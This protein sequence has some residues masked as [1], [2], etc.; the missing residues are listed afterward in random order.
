MKPPP[1]IV[2]FRNDLRLSDNPTLTEALKEGC[3]VVPV[4]VWDPER[5]APW[6]PGAAS[7]S[8]LHH[9]L[10]ALDRSIHQLGSRLIVR[11]GESLRELLK[12][13][14]ETGARRIYRNTRYEPMVVASDLFIRK[15][16]EYGG[17]ETVELPGNLLFEP[18]EVEKKSGGPYQVFTP[19]WRHCWPIIQ[20]SPPA[21]LPA[22]ES[23][24]PVSPKLKSLNIDELDLAPPLQWDRGFYEVFTPGEAGAHEALQSFLKSY[25]SDYQIR[26][27]FPAQ[28]A[29]SSLS[30]HLHFGEI[31][32]RQIYDGLRYEG[33]EHTKGAER[34]MAE[35]IWR[36]FAH[37]LLYH[38]PH[39]TDNPLKTN[40]ER[41]PWRTSPENLERWQ[42][43][44]TGIPIIDAGMQQLWAT[45]WM[46]NRVR[47]IVGSFLVKNLLIH[48]KE[49]AR[50]F[51][52]TL[53]D[54]DLANNTLGWQWIAGSGADA[55]PYFRIF[56][57][58]TQSKKFDPD[59]EY[60]RKWVPELS[61]V[62]KSQIHT[63]W[64]F[65][66]TIE[67]TG[68]PM[69]KISLTESRVRALEAYKAT[70]LAD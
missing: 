9:S 28:P 62:S 30:P 20:H 11:E 58:V 38:F 26:R 64:R 50:W 21:P 55:A 40:F 45:G 49:G 23:L 8:W 63:P 25:L 17:I 66:D 16:L 65:P 22:P 15:E 56:N 1:V 4:F 24:P 60:I 53:V 6:S 54:A 48:W 18:D 12:L 42:Q 19:F 43:G 44:K 59:G 33:L 14:K 51:W 41:F 46:H 7:R 34:F 67:T 36:E 57:P 31:T 52:D 3:E 32:P 47:M 37:H 2:W 68:Y 27:D 39:T 13:C 35:V 61:D 69:I 29:T 70:Q 10:K 5:E